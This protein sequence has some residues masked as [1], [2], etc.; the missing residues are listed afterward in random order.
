MT[1]K[2]T[3]SRSAGSSDD[4]QEGNWLRRVRRMREAMVARQADPTKKGGIAL[5][6]EMRRQVLQKLVQVSSQCCL[7]LEIIHEARDVLE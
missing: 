1:K 3:R 6:K 5:T 2:N 7:D 4:P